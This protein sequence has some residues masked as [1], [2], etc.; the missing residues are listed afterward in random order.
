MI[1]FG[2][3]HPYRIHGR[4]NQQNTEITTIDDKHQ[5]LVNEDLGAF[6][7]RIKASATNHG[8]KK[9]TPLINLTNKP[10]ITFVLSGQVLT[11]PWFLGSYEGSD[12]WAVSMINLYKDSHNIKKSWIITNDDP[13]NNLTTNILTRIDLDISR[14]YQ[15]IEILNTQGHYKGYKL[16]KPINH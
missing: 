14:D 15:K 5:F 13:L 6:L 7:S 8:W 9:N 12:D 16:W 2:F 11:V 4:I 3:K 10:G 1:F